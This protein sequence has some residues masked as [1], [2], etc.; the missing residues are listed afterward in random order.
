MFDFPYAE[1]TTFPIS[2]AHVP[3]QRTLMSSSSGS[4][5]SLRAAS[6]A[7]AALFL[8]RSSFVLL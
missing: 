1:P 2:G 4:T 7:Q 6:A 5:P 8:S 3:V